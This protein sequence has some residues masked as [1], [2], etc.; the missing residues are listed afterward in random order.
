MAA[1]LQ[2]FIAGRW[3]AG[4]GTPIALR[5]ATTGE[6]IASA[7]SDGLDISTSLTH[8]REVGGANLR[9]LTFH[10]RAAL[11][12]AL[13]KHISDRKEELYALS[14]ATGAT[15]VRFL[16]RH[17][18]RYR[19]SLRL[20]EQGHA[21]AARRSRLPRR[22]YR[23][24]V[25]IRRLRRSAHLRAARRRGGAH[26]RLQLPCLG[27]AGE[28]GTDFPRRR[29][30]DRQARHCHLL[31]H[32]AGGAPHRGVGHSPGRR[33]AAHLR[34]CWQS[35][36]ASHLS[37]RRCLHRLGIDGAQAA[38]ACR[39]DRSF[40]TI[41]G[42]DRLAQLL[43]ARAGCGAGNSRSSTSSCARWCAR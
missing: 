27:H 32:G 43:G 40:R 12:K 20:C 16:D 6:V 28:A 29:T 10:D 17:R 26:Q 15:R 33:A 24:P 4:T 11:L 25:E 41:H 34:Q 30:H 1:Q 36:R 21:R 7:S 39:R 31:S 3:Q 18:R 42:G 23:K 38:D 22:R 19:H 2:S 37:G 13:A 5:D 35:V 8:A 9:R 14:S